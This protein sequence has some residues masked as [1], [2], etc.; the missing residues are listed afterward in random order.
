M[1][2]N[3]TKS[4]ISGRIT[5]LKQTPLMSL[6]LSLELH[7]S[8]P[9]NNN[10]LKK[11]NTHTHMHTKEIKMLLKKQFE[12]EL[13]LIF[14]KTVEPLDQNITQRNINQTHFTHLNTTLYFM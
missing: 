1:S 14:I 8:F 5:E 7:W 10:D 11:T 13:S 6:F 2:L 12:L 3:W 4:G 9:Y